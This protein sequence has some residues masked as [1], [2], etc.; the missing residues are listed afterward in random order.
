MPVV[1]EATREMVRR[2]R[3]QRKVAARVVFLHPS[4]KGRGGGRRREEKKKRETRG[5]R[6][7]KIDRVVVAI[8]TLRHSSTRCR[9]DC[10]GVEKMRRFQ[11]TCRRRAF[12][13]SEQEN[14]GFGF[15][16]LGFGFESQFPQYDIVA[17]VRFGYRHI[18]I[19]II[20]SSGYRCWE[21]AEL[22]DFCVRLPAVWNSDRR[23]KRIGGSRATVK[24]TRDAKD[25]PLQTRQNSER[26][27]RSGCK[28]GVGTRRWFIC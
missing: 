12:Q 6:W 10:R 7:L 3:L 13:I 21:V 11:T 4:L 24:W 2:R 18:Y 25:C 14:E 5:G 15:W 17:R 16:T 20:C 26:I 9:S 19:Y 8:S 27:A 1:E 23:T 28:K 22:K